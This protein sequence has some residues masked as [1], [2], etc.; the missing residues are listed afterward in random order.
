MAGGLAVLVDFL[1][2]K[3]PKDAVIIRNG[4]RISQGGSP[5]TG[6]LRQI[7]FT[8]DGKTSGWVTTLEAFLR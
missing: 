1:V 8:S 3:I 2:V 7:G 5:I 4:Q 6:L